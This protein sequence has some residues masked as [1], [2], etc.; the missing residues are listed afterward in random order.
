MSKLCPE[1]EMSSLHLMHTDIGQH[2][3]FSLLQPVHGLA[4]CTRA[5]SQ[6]SST[7]RQT[8][9]RIQI[10]IAAKLS[11]PRREVNITRHGTVGEH[12][13]N[14]QTTDAAVID[15]TCDGAVVCSSFARPKHKR[16][17]T[18]PP[19]SRLPR[20][21]FVVFVVDRPATKIF[22]EKESDRQS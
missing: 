18:P 8:A 14:A 10:R 7:S 6:R 20:L 3:V 9:K 5:C 13:T 22:D 17:L 4:A 2:S 1:R 11:S 21:V 12:T 19:V 16:H 15:T